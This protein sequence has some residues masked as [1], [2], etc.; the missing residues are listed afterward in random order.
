MYY[1]AKAAMSYVHKMGLALLVEKIAGALSKTQ[2]RKYLPSIVILKNIL[3][4]G[5]V[6][7]DTVL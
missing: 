1:F 6:M 3:H 7:K 5:L 2:T 4:E